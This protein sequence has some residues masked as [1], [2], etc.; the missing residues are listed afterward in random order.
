MAYN[1][2]NPM[3]AGSPLWPMEPEPSRDI[4]A[5]RP[6]RAQWTDA[7]YTDKTHPQEMFP[8]SD[9]S[10]PGRRIPRGYTPTQNRYDPY[11]DYAG[12]EAGTKT[13]I[14]MDEAKVL[15]STV[16]AVACVYAEEM[17]TIDGQNGRERI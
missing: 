9:A 15:D 12:Y 16:W 6:L 7:Y 11:C 14:D 2:G 5:D 8:T 10:D 4:P 17:Q 1:N 3:N 13:I